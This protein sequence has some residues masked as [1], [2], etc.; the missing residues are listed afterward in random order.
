MF[1]NLLMLAAT[2]ASPMLSKPSLD[3]ECR[4]ERFDVGVP[5]PGKAR[6]FKNVKMGERL[7]IELSVTWP[8]R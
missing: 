3:V 7:R 8:A 2:M 4:V 5:V 6:M 1:L